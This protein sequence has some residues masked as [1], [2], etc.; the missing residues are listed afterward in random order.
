MKTLILTLILT[1]V[2]GGF[3]QAEAQT[4]Q[5]KLH[6]NQQKLVY[7]GKLKIRFVSLV[8]DSRCPAD[9][10]CIWA[11]NAKIKIEVRKY[12]S[13]TKTFELNT[14]LADKTA[15]FEN[16]EIML[17]SLAPHPRSNIRINQ[18]SYTATLSVT[19]LTR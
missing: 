9:V 2:F 13:A 19:K 18:R 1:F 12:G 7:R 4:S 5:V 15:R 10:N 17:V 16:Y 6:V 3:V 11:G 8:E 14:N